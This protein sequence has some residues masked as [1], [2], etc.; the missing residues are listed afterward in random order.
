MQAELFPSDDN[1]LPDGAVSGMIE[2]T[3]GVKLRYARF[4]ATG[5]P[6]RGTVIVLQGRNECIEKYFETFRDLSRRGFA[7]AMLD[8]RGQGG[9][10]RL[11]KDRQ[12]G[13]IDD[14]GT[15]VEDLDLFFEQVVLPDCRGPFFVL[16]H[17]TGALI[18]LL[19]SRRLANRVERMVLIAPL[20]TLAASRLSTGALCRLTGLLK[21]IGL[22]SVYVGSG[23][24]PVDTAPFAGNALT[25]DAGRYGRNTRLYE[26]HP[27]LALGGPTA[28]W[29]RAACL[30]MN[31]A[32]DPEFASHLS[33]S[34]LIVA[35]AQD[36]VVSTPAIEHYARRLRS[37][38]CLTIDGAR[39]E[40]LQETDRVRGQFWAAFDAFI[41]GADPGR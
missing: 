41:P 6:L 3:R 34:V 16:A 8:W 11:L 7:S 26:R 14:F 17:S 20:L 40:I 27:E 2:G 21:G 22:G 36:T 25:T 30:A 18:A 35:A 29:I 31:E 15:Y 12:R 9:S 10:D 23:R 5:R 39:H 4:A 32:L 13:H 19:A 38:Y 33:Q 37:G 24:R 1:P 28:A